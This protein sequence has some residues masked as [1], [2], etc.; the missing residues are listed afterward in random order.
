MSGR[1]QGS[2]L[3]ESKLRIFISP[4]LDLDREIWQLVCCQNVNELWSLGGGDQC[5]LHGGRVFVT[6][7]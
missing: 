4:G 1:S 7:D 2:E 3:K 5:I 6:V